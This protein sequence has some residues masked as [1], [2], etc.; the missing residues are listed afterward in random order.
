MENITAVSG[1]QQNHSHTDI[2]YN[3]WDIACIMQIIII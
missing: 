3:K 1:L 2:Q